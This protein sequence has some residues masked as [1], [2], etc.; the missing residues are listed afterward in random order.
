MQFT[1]GRAVD[2][3]GNIHIEGQGVPPT[4]KVPV[5]EETLFS[6]GDPILEA[7][8]AYLD[9]A[10][11]IETTDA[12]EITIGDEVTGE[13]AAGERV[14]YTLEVAKG[15]QISIYLGDEAGELDTVL[16]L[17]DTGDNVLT[18]NDDADAD[19]VN[20]ALTELD[21]PVDLTL[22]IEVATK[23]DNGEGAYTLRVVDATT[24]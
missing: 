9:D 23:G 4:V 22:V 1:V 6:D 11:N 14:R 7:A 18:G 8:I 13:I 21:I 16:N 10:T 19:T 5:D 12:G 15:D 24:E 20:S 17:L 3:N 2:M